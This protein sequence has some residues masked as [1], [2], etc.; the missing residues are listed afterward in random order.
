MDAAGQADLGVLGQGSARGRGDGEFEQLLQAAPALQVQ[1]GGRERDLLDGRRAGVSVIERQVMPLP[2]WWPY[3]SRCRRG[4][5]GSVTGPVA[6]SRSIV[7]V[8][9][10]TCGPGRSQAP[11]RATSRTTSPA[12]GP[13]R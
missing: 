10:S 7:V 9:D 1:R 12:I 5:S 13:C 4:C 8:I 3:C 11:G 6:A 2:K